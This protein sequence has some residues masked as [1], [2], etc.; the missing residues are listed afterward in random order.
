M[1]REGCGEVGAQSW[2]WECGSEQK[3]CVGGVAWGVGVGVPGVPE[4]PHLKSSRQIS[5]TRE[6]PRKRRAC[7][8]KVI[9]KEA[10]CVPPT[11]H[12]KN[13]GNP[14]ETTCI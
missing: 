10:P 12:T 1:G 9:C 3:Q 7:V 11:S 5:E 14:P 8:F 2:R 13:G 6:V 4:S